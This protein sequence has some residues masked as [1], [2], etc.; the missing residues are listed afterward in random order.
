MFKIRKLGVNV[1]KLS[2]TKFPYN[3]SV[4]NRTN[5]VRGFI[6]IE[7][8]VIPVGA[9]LAPALFSFHIA[10]KRQPYN[11]GGYLRGRGQAPPL[12]VLYFCRVKIAR[13]RGAI[14]FC[15]VT[16]VR[17]RGAI[18]TQFQNSGCVANWTVAFFAK[19][20]LE[21][22]CGR[23][24]EQKSV[25]EMEKIAGQ[26]RN[27]RPAAGSVPAVHSSI[28][29]FVHSSVS[30]RLARLPNSPRLSALFLRQYHFAICFS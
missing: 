2:R 8:N 13:C 23:R 27:D 28:C 7:N 18:Y 21:M 10:G 20:L 24:G 29:P 12:P 5:P 15:R 25:R 4:P 16:L 1:V 30:C 11:R 19:L 17:C 6:S 3:S 9:R 22:T 14:Y 26:A